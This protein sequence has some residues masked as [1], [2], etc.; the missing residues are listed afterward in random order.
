MTAPLLTA[1]HRREIEHHT[2]AGRAVEIREVTE[3]MVPW[4]LR[5]FARVLKSYFPDEGAFRGLRVLDCGCGYGIMSI[6][7][8][9]R[10][11]FLDAF[12]ISEHCVGIARRFCAA[13]G[14]EDRVDVRVAVMERLDYPAGR[15]DLV[16]GTRILHHVDIASAAAE[17]HRVL[18]PGG[19]A[20]FLEPTLRNPVY[21]AIRRLYR[22]VPVLPRTG[23]PDEHPLTVQEM[24]TLSNTFDGNF[25]MHGA[26]FYL[27]SH[28]ARA[29]GLT[30]IM[31]V[32]PALSLLDRCID[33]AFPILR[34]SNVHQILAMRKAGE[35]ET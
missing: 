5:A 27:F 7:I 23:S 9:K 34:R 6:L 17:V 20:L 30:R 24:G 3:A 11:A 25:R 2:D 13:N 35:L 32:G 28:M 31:G 8:A 1:R 26:P 10:G 4:N 18:K 12:D 14:V 19:M 29:V 33:T 15:F 21:N 22:A 16:L